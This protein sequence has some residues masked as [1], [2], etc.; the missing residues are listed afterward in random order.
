MGKWFQRAHEEAGLQKK[1]VPLGK[2][3][4][5]MQL[6]SFINETCFFLAQSHTT[7]A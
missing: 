1:R 5:A 7:M 6:E 2:N 4:M 3:S